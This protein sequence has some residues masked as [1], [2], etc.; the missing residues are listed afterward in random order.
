M[1]Y[2]VHKHAVRCITSQFCFAV[3]H[4]KIYKLTTTLHMADFVRSQ[5]SV[6][7]VMIHLIYVSGPEIKYVQSLKRPGQEEDVLPYLLIPL[8]DVHGALI[9][10][11][12]VGAL[13]GVDR[14]QL[15]VGSQPV[16][17]SITVCEHTRLQQLVI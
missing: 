13:G 4:S 9:V 11:V 5:D 17:L 15:V 6:L 16:P 7:C 2:T 3:S 10:V 12:L 1:L 8:C 14:Q